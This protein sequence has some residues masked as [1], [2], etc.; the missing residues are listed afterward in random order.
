VSSFLFQLLFVWIVVIPAGIVL[1]AATY[2]RL[3]SARVRR[4]QRRAADR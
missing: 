4:A 1:V 2:P 3:L